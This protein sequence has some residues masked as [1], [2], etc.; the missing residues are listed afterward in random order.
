MYC[1]EIAPAIATSEEKVVNITQARGKNSVRPHIVQVL[2]TKAKDFGISQQEAIESAFQQGRQLAEAKR[3][4]TSFEYKCFLGKLGWSMSWATKLV[5]VVQTF[6]D[7]GTFALRLVTLETLKA[8]CIPKYREIVERMRGR[9]DLTDIMVRKW[10]KEIKPP[11]KPK[12]EIA[13][14]E[15]GWQRTADGARCFQIAPIHNDEIGLHLSHLAKVE[16]LLP[17]QLVEKW[18]EK[19][20]QFVNAQPDIERQTRVDSRQINDAPDWVS[21]EEFCEK[22][23]ERFKNAIAR[24]KNEDKWQL[25]EKLSA[26]LISN[27]HSFQ[28]M[29]WLPSGLLIKALSR[30]LLSPKKLAT[31]PLVLSQ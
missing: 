22:N 16:N 7:M 4:F 11:Q 13:P 23:S 5:R 6:G 15:E 19:E 1:T 26:F 25:I 24:F 29:N 21:V 31:P 17:H 28:K 12:K 10:M 18:I 2:E 27:P 9:T 30:S 8:L 3:L 20:Y 14:K